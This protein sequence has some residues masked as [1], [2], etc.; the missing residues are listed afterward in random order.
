MPPQNS[1]DGESALGR[2]RC[3]RQRLLLRQPRLDDV[4][5]GDVDRLERVV[6][7][8]HIGHVDGLDLAD[9]LE[10]GTELAGEAFQLVVAQGEA[11]QA[12]E[13]GYLVSGDLHDSEA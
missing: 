7:G 12:G 1:R 13:V 2:L 4:R 6:G 11:S 9:V 10:D 3:L 8:L 5:P